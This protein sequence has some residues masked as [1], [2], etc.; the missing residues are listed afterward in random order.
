MDIK[1]QLKKKL[2]Q[3]TEKHDQVKQIALKSVIG[4][5]IIM[6]ALTLLSRMAASITT[7][8]VKVSTPRAGRIEQKVE[9]TGTIKTQNEE[10]MAVGS[11]L[12]VKEVFVKEGDQVVAG[13]QI[14]RAS[15]RER[16]YVLV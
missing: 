4:F 7:A 13:D 10:S 16:V 12:S 2:P 5:T 15:C 8:Q 14:G 9:A 1:S 3:R 6:I 11:G